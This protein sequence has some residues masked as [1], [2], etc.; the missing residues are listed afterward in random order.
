MA[1]L[2]ACG[3]HA[4]ATRAARRMLAEPNASAEDRARAGA[5]LASLAP[6]PFAV[7][8]GVAGTAL[9]IALGVWVGLGGAR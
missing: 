2:L 6:E 7:M 8:A 1:E 5:V 9:A 3:A 4:A